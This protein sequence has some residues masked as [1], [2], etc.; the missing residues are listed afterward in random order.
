MCIRDSSRAGTCLNNKHVNNTD[1]RYTINYTI[2][3]FLC[4]VESL[5]TFWESNTCMCYGCMYI[6]A[7]MYLLSAA[8]KSTKVIQK[9]QTKDK[10]CQNPQK[11]NCIQMQNMCNKVTGGGRVTGKDNVKSLFQGNTEASEDHESCRY[12][13]TITTWVPFRFFFYNVPTMVRVGRHK[14]LRIMVRDKN[15]LVF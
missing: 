1:A 5:L 9:N 14:E 2:Q 8:V 6:H 7:T 3:L 11:W 15:C 10:I 13:V 4:F 12:G